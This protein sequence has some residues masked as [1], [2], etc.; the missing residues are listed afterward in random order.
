MFALGL[1]YHHTG[2]VSGFFALR[3][4]LSILAEKVK[5]HSQCVE[6]L[7]LF[8]LSLHLHCI[9][10]NPLRASIFIVQKRVWCKLRALGS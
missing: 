10:Q 7:S 2:P 3:E 6:L 5:G 1:R 9:C 4:S 8:M